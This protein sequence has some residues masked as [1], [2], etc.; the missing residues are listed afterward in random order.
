MGF[1]KGCD[2]GFW[3]GDSDGGDMLW[4]SDDGL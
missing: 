2:D 1:W 3:K 4:E